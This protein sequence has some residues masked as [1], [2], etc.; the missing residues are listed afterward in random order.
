MRVLR[1]SSILLVLLFVSSLWLAFTPKTALAAQC[2]FALNPSAPDQSMAKLTITISSK[3]LPTTSSYKVVM[4]EP[5]TVHVFAKKDL[6]FINIADPGEPINPQ[7]NLSFDKPIDSWVAGQY[8]IFLNDQAIS[9]SL[10][11]TAVC[12]HSFPLAKTAVQACTLNI[13]NTK[14]EPDTDVTL[15]IEGTLSPSD[16]SVTSPWG[17]Y[18]IY[19]NN[20]VK[21]LYSTSTG[22]RINLKNHRVGDYLVEIKDRCGIIGSSC[23]GREPNNQCKSVAFRVAQIGS[24]GGG[25]IDTP[26]PGSSAKSCTPDDVKAGRCTSAAG[27]TCDI[28]SSTAPDPQNPPKP[29]PKNEGVFTAIGCIP[30]NP[31][32]LINS[33]LKVAA[34]ASGGIALLLMIFGG[35]RIMT[36]AGNA[37]NLKAGQEQFT[38]AAVGL[39]FVIFSI[40]LLQIIGVQ[41]LDIPGFG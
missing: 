10:E 24:G 30:T 33:F 18:D 9:G 15:V 16:V 17:G 35:I 23:W 1:F 5:V 3:D 21:Y 13:E 7:I 32:T 11:Q 26:T 38:S 12:T 36:A 20:E 22:T 6:K 19:I 41:I 4:Q 29:D 27:Q 34:L 31:I 39:L 28:T 25:K 14:I 8:Q 40:L 37:D 2:T